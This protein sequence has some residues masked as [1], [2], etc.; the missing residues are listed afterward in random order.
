M[1][2][3]LHPIFSSRFYSFI[4]EDRLLATN[5]P[6]HHTDIWTVGKVVTTSEYIIL[7]LFDNDMA[8]CN[9]TLTFPNVCKSYAKHICRTYSCNAVGRLSSTASWWRHQMAIFSALLA[10]CVGNSPVSGEFPSQRPVTRSFDVFFDLRLNKQLSKQSRRW[11]F[12][13]PSRSL[14]RHC[15][16]YL[17]LNINLR[18]NRSKWNWSR[19][20]RAKFTSMK[21]GD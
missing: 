13:T 14:W 6:F 12:E 9:V 7:K 1:D 3:K 20:E 10:L 8:F 11:W 21:H 16:D 15:D 4:D 17:R 19:L 18:A 2:E 5:C